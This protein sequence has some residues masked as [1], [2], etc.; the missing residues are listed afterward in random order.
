VRLT[1]PA[2]APDC[3]PQDKPPP[4]DGCDASLDWWFTDE[5]L[6]PKPGKP[7]PPL[8]MADM[9]PACRRIAID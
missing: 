4:G 6:N 5:A 3:A 2:D 9:P 7:R 8:R 1:C